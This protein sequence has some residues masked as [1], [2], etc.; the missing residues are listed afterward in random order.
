MILMYL[1]SQSFRLYLRKQ[2]M[3]NFLKYHCYLKY[4]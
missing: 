1:K 2:T 4:R 3:Q